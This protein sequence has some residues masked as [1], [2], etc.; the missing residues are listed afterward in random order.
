MTTG[1]WLSFAKN[2]KNFMSTDLG[3]VLVKNGSREF[4][5]QI[6]QLTKINELI[7]WLMRILGGCVVLGMSCQLGEGRANWFVRTEGGKRYTDK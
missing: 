4:L 7:F 2:D 6:G 3:F 5:C 1:I